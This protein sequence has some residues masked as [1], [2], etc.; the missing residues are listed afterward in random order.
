MRE[1][2]AVVL[3]PYPNAKIIAAP[4]EATTLP[5]HSIDVIAC[6][7]S[8]HWFDPDAFRAE[9]GRIGK[10]NVLVIAVYNNTPGGN[11]IAHGRESTE[12]FFKNPEVKEFPNPM[13]YTRERWLAYMTSHSHNP[14]PSDPGYDAHIAEANETFDRENVDGLLKRDVVTRVYWERIWER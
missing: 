14:L 12:V 11:A 4:A 7:Q 3:E 1:Q 5:D 13:F 10:D 9:C 8:L 2:L 6:A